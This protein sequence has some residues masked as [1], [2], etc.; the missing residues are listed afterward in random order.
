MKHRLPIAALLAGLLATPALAETRTEQI[1][2][3]NGSVLHQVAAYLNTGIGCVK[4]LGTAEY[5]TT[6]QRAVLFINTL[7]IPGNDG[8]TV[9][10]NY[11]TLILSEH[12]YRNVFAIMDR[13]GIPPDQ[14]AAKCSSTLQIMDASIVETLMKLKQ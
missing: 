14:R 8:E 7:N 4:Y 6:K 2:D 10:R 11:R 12:S 1:Q 9:I 3:I 5:D 13:E